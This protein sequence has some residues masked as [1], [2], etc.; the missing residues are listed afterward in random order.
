MWVFILGIDEKNEGVIF[1]EGV[2][3]YEFVEKGR[4]RERLNGVEVLKK[5]FVLRILVLVVLVWKILKDEVEES[6]IVG[7]NL[8]F[9]FNDNLELNG[10]VEF[11]IM[12]DFFV[13]KKFVLKFIVIWLKLKEKEK[14]NL[15]FIV[16]DD[17]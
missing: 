13:G 17:E 7:W 4:E 1:G 12:K 6:D 2:S 3:V 10:E 15:D 16:E 5:G 9:F 8:N 14:N 11:D